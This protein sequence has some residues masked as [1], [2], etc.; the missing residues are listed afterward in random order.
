MEQPKRYQYLRAWA[1]VGRLWFHY[2]Q[3]GT[4]DESKAW[5]SATRKSNAKISRTPYQLYHTCAGLPFVNLDSATLPALTERVWKSKGG[6]TRIICTSAPPN[7]IKC[8]KFLCW[9]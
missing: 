8:Q 6:A 9:Y 4:G 2:R 7:Q 1:G 5:H 3:S